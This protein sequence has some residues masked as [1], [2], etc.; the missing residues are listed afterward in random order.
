MLNLYSMC[1]AQ[2]ANLGKA[3][4]SLLVSKF[5]YPSPLLFCLLLFP[6]APLFILFLYEYFHLGYSYLLFLCALLPASLQFPHGS[7]AP[8]HSKVLVRFELFL[9]WY[10]LFVFLNLRLLFCNTVYCTSLLFGFPLTNV[11][12][13]GTSIVWLQTSVLTS[14]FAP[15]YRYSCCFPLQMAIH[16]AYLLAYLWWSTGYLRCSWH[17]CTYN[18]T[19]S[20]AVPVTCNKIFWI[21]CFH[22]LNPKE[23][24]YF[25]SHKMSYTLI[26]P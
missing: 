12:P 20:D 5:F 9:C 14:R 3:P 21:Q 17:H 23:S 15:S 18:S 13:A 10:S 7:A 22:C 8:F 16:S 2:V 4:F 11:S 24:I 6:S 19:G 26:M 1:A 25:S